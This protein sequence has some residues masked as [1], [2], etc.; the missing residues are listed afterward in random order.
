[1]AAAMLAEIADEPCELSDN[2]AEEVSPNES[3]LL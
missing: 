3:I 1:M 2:S